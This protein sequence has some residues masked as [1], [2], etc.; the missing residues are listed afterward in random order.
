MSATA[1]SLS[2]ED[3]GR[4]G[5]SSI[6]GRFLAENYRIGV[7]GLFKIN[8]AGNIVHERWKLVCPAPDA[9]TFPLSDPPI[10][11]KYTVWID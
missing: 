7:G 10:I 5:S 11:F 8:L 9:S 2:W 3:G 4:D 1:S 6:E